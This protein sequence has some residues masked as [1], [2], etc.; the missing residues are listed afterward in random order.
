[1]TRRSKTP[2]E[3]A[4]EQL[5]AAKRHKERLKTKRDTLAAELDQ[6]N[7]E[8]VRRRRR[9]ALLPAQAPRPRTAHDTQHRRHHPMT[10]TTAKVRAKGL[11]ATGVTEDIANQMYAHKGKH[12]MAIVEVKV[13][14]RHDKAGG[15]RRVDL[16]IEQFEP[17]VDDDLEAH[18]RELTRTLY[19][20]RA[21]ADG[22]AAI[23]DTLTPSLTDAIKAGQGFEPHPFVPVDPSIENPICDRCGVV[24]KAGQHFEFDSDDGEPVDDSSDQPQDGVEEGAEPVPV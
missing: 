8:R 21:H 24:E 11:D 19:A 3:R 22:Q 16:V 4:Q 14:E 7:R 23:D 1:M 5:D 2:R 13:D 6:V 12:Y 9:P 17:A 20:N 18:L 10:D 15:Q